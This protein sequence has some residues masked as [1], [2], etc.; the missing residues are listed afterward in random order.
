M[1]GWWFCWC[2]SLELVLL[3][4]LSSQSTG[5]SAGA[6]AWGLG[7]NWGGLTADMT[8]NSSLLQDPIG[9]VTG[10]GEDITSDTITL[11]YSF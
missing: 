8:V 3:V 4:Q 7:F 10:Y 11:T 9:T 6:F 5:G 2:T 1:Q